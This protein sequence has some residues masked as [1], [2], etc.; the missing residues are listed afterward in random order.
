MRIEGERE[1]REV[2]RKASILH[3]SHQ[4]R[5]QYGRSEGNKKASCL[6]CK[7][8]RQAWNVEVES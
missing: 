5:G 1:D 2:E 3:K 6:R 4:E 8:H 7:Y